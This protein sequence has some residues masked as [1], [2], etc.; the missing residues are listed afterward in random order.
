MALFTYLIDTYPPQ[1]LN[2][3]VTANTTIRSVSAAAFV[4]FA[5]PMYTGMG[6]DWASTLLAFVGVAL[7]PAAFGFW[8]FGERVRGRSRFAMG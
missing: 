2:S 8:W 3:A 7:F 6:V 1:H 5:A 4:M